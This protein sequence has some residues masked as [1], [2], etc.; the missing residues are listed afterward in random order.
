MRKRVK[1]AKEGKCEVGIF[2]RKCGVDYIMTG[3]ST[4]QHDRL[5]NRDETK[6]HIQDII[7]NVPAEWRELFVSRTCPSCWKKMFG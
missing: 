4:E 1:V 3:F 5:F 2:C 6:E 7:P